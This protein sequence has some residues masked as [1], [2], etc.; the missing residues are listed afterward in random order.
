MVTAFTSRDRP[1][2][3]YPDFSSDNH[4]DELAERPAFAAMVIPVRL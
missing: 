1:A 2:L 3:K 4:F